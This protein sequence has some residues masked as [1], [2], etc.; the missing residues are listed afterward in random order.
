MQLRYLYARLDGLHHALYGDERIIS[1]L[2][3]P[4]DV[5]VKMVGLLVVI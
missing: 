5:L 2:A 1:N 4:Q 3:F